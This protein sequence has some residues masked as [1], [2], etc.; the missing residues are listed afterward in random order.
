[1]LHASVSIQVICLAATTSSCCPKAG[2]DQCIRSSRSGSPFS[3]SNPVLLQLLCVCSICQWGVTYANRIDM[4]DIMSSTAS[5]THLLQLLLCLVLSPLPHVKKFL[6]T[7][8]D[9]WRVVTI[10]RFGGSLFG[11]FWFQELNLYQ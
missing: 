5:P 7:R 11:V 3:D 10:L 1:M 8:S 4:W 6:A 9:A 2:V